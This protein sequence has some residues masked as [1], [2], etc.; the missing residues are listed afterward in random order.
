MSLRGALNILRARRQRW[1]KRN[2]AGHDHVNLERV[3]D[4]FPEKDTRTELEGTACVLVRDSLWINVM[5]RTDG[6]GLGAR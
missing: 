5:V 1:Q 3:I 2:A 6:C 4:E